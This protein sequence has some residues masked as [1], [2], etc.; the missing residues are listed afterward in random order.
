MTKKVKT[1]RLYYDFFDDVKHYPDAVV[2]VVISQRG[3]GKTYGFLN[4]ARK[5]KIPI[6]YMKRCI[7]DINTICTGDE[8]ADINP[9][10]PIN[11]DEGCNVKP[12]ALKKGLGYFKDGEEDDEFL[13]GYL[14]ALNALKYIRGVDFSDACYCCLD[15]FCGSLGE[16]LSRT[17]GE[18]LLDCYMTFNRDREDRGLDPMKLVLFSNSDEI[19]SPITDT[20]EIADMIMELVASG[21][22]IYYD[23]E[24]RILIHY[25]T[26]KEYPVTEQAKKGIFAT[27]KGTD[28]HA[29]AFSAAFV[30]NDFSQVNKKTIA[31]SRCIMK[32]TYKHKDIYIYENADSGKLYFCNIPHQTRCKYNFDKESDRVRFV[33]YDNAYIRSAIMNGQATFEKFTYYDLFMNFVKKFGM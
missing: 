13:V 8:L 2:Y 12:V 7:E 10:K 24:R 6:I 21:K 22:F 23:Q 16:K 17:E 18:Q 28:W 32:C 14:A 19:M 9:Y 3:I 26:D 30:H 11:R 27:M 25:V 1:N 4:G 15:E 33:H 29:K 31:H 20:L 5:K